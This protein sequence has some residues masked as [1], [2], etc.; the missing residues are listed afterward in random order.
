MEPGSLKTLVASPLKPSCCLS[1]LFEIIAGR[2]SGVLASP[3]MLFLELRDL[4]IQKID[5]LFCLCKL[6]CL[7]N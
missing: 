7:A 1:S 3:V 2:H 4:G 6:A 5:P